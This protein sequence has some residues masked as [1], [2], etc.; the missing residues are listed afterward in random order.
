VNLRE[1]HV[2]VERRPV[3]RPASEADIR[4]AQ[5]A[6]TIEVREKAEQPVVQKE[7]RV[8]EEVRVGKEATERTETVRETVRK[9][10]VQVEE[11]DKTNV[12]NPHHQQQ[13][14]QQHRP[15]AGA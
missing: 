1:E 15:P 10:D 7:A 8:V 4:R 2:R 14:Q 13:Q 6:G 11:N 12:D 3:D 9:T 5:Q